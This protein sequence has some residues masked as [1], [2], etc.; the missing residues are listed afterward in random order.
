MI[1][2][3]F[4]FSEEIILRAKKAEE[5]CA[6]EFAKIDEIAEWNSGKVHNA[7]YNNRIS[8]AHLFGTTGYG[9]GDRG[10]DALD[11]VYAEIFGAER[12]LVRSFMISGTHAIA[13]MLFGVLR[14]GDTALSITGAPYDTLSDVISK[15]GAGS[16]A[17]Y[18]INF[19]KAK[20]IDGKIDY[21]ALSEALKDKPRMIYIQRSGG[22]S[23]RSA[24]GISEI[25]K[26]CEIVRATSEKTI[27][28]VDN[29]YGEFSETLEPCDVGADI[30]AGSL[31]KNPGGG[32]ALCGGY[33]AGKKE[34]VD[35]AAY[36]LTS[37]AIGTKAGATMEFNRGAFQGI[38]NA[39]HAV[40]Q[41]LKAAVFASALFEGMG[42]ETAPKYSEQRSDIITAVK[43]GSPAALLKFCAGIQ[44]GS[45]IDSFVTPEAWDMPGYQDE[46]VM[47]SGA[48]VA[49][50]SIELSADGPMR[51]PYYAYLQGGTIYSTAKIGIMTAAE[52]LC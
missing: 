2:E 40:G 49:G 30:I 22:Y 51:E 36:R 6:R 12:A 5:L 48:F 7:F 14:P 42:F 25:K 11:C 35:L 20:L 26:V 32:I 24:I 3:R 46:V 13:T 1:F 23:A 44:K 19:V 38:Y 34:L 8:E 45:P 4:N 37:P 39:P 16:L 43:C 52:A 28:A 50:S 15:S 29:C 18:N 33:I 17:D 10:R 47:A 9:Y 41:A 21:D 31:I 27:V